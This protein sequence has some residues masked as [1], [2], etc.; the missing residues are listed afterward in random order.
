MTPTMLHDVQTKATRFNM[1]NVDKIIIYK[2]MY[3]PGEYQRELSQSLY[4]IPW[5]Y[6]S[7]CMKVGYV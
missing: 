3:M 6:P 5:A 7:N 2:Y 1:A 4:V